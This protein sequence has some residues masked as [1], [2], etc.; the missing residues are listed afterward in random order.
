[1]LEASALSLEGEAAADAAPVPL[2]DAEKRLVLYAIARFESGLLP[3]HIGDPA[4]LAQSYG[5]C[6]KNT[7]GAGLS[8]GYIQFTQHSGNL[9]KLL[10]RLRDRDS[11]AFASCFGADADALLQ[12][13]NAA[14]P[15]Q[16]LQPVGQA[17]LWADG[18]VA[19]F[20]EAAK[21]PAFQEEQDRLAIESFVNPN[22]LLA[23]LLGFDTDRALA[24]LLD[25]C[26]QQ[27]N[28]GGRSWV[29]SRVGPLQNDEL[30]RQALDALGFE[31]LIDFQ[32]TV[33]GLSADGKWGPLTH[34]ALL[35][36]LRALGDHTPIAV[37][38]REQ[39]L[40]MLVAS[41]AAEQR[42]WAHRPQ[43]LRQDAELLRD[44]RFAL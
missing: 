36:S 29:V 23:T 16:R 33:Q 18:W 28:G 14:T 38:T 27:G 40:D 42:S 43:A 5:A 34:A 4:Q 19:R 31:H 24:M 3:A 39:M 32:S 44:V 6:N 30:R 22:V 13:T 21:I 26:I 11:A 9:G 10:K 41:A 17:D 7:D 20:R 2:N 25:R 15:E 12:T 37:P 8:Y 1:M 35:S